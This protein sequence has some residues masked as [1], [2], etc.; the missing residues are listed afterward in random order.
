MGR[1]R[2]VPVA[3]SLAR[4]TWWMGK[5]QVFRKDSISKNK[6]GAGETTEPLRTFV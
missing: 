1:H 3:Y 4:L 6:V 5:P 2:L